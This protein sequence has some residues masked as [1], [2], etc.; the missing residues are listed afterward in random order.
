MTEDPANYTPMG[1]FDLIEVWQKDPGCP[2]C[3]LTQRHVAQFYYTLLFDQ[4]IQPESHAAFRAGRG[5]CNTHA[6]QL[7]EQQG[8]L[9]NI[10]VYYQHVGRDLLA[11]LD[12]AGSGGGEGLARFLKGS[13]GSGSAVADA[14]EP[15]GPCVACKARDYAANLYTEIIAKHISDARLADAYRASEGLCLPH[16]R[17][18]LRQVAP[19]ENRR[20]LVG[21]QREIWRALFAELDAFIEAHDYRRTDRMG[22]EGD[23]WLR[24]IRA[25]V[26]EAGVG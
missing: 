4:L 14:L 5:L 21:I 3:A 19:P 13:R 7:R 2:V 20:L 16:F 11:A 25:L 12:G 22:A 17:R 24:V 9:L 15:S 6:W 10:A 23:A 1:L 26:G 18:T 8:A